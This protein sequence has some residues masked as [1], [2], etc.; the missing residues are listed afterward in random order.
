MTYFT[1]DIKYNLMNIEKVFH[2]CSFI[3][4]VD[5]ATFVVGAQHRM[6]FKL[7]NRLVDGLFSAKYTRRVDRF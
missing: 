3:G 6:I 2:G 1:N 5:D 7:N 4:K